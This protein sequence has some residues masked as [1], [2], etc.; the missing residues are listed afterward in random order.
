MEINWKLIPVNLPP[1]VSYLSNEP[2]VAT[3]YVNE[4][5]IR[6]YT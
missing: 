5:S 2:S 1:E 3:A 4:I 6:I